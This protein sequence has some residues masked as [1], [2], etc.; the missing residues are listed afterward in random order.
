MGFDRGLC[1]SIME[2]YTSDLTY[3]TQ[4]VV[5]DG[6]TE[7]DVSGATGDNAVTPIEASDQPNKFPRGTCY[8]FPLKY[9]GHES[10]RDLTASLSKSLPNCKL[11]AQLV[12]Q[13]GKK[14]DHLSYQL[15]CSCY[16][17]T[18]KSEFPERCFTQARTRVVRN[19]R[20]NSKNAKT[21]VDRMQHSKLKGRNVQKYS[22][23]KEEKDK[24]GQSTLKNRTTSERPSLADNRCHMKINML[25]SASDNHFYLKTNSILKHRFHH[26]LSSETLTLNKRNIT[27]TEEDWIQEMYAKG[28]SDGTI[29]SIM[30]GVFNKKGQSGEF[31]NPL[32]AIV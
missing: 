30:T 25:L 10:W 7:I 5:N 18:E 4:L 13:K 31:T 2:V 23:E 20:T 15:R 24:P 28:L 6:K 17:L 12:G 11:V 3:N 1:E 26:P 29:A 27:E 22:S 21:V 9:I 19:K 8:R 14:S 32:S 16:Y